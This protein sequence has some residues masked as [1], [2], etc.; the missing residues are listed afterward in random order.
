MHGL[1][2]A[3]LIVITLILAIGTLLCVGIL[4]AIAIGITKLNQKIEKITDMAEPVVNKASDTLDTVQRV[5][6]NVGEK[7]DVILTRGVELTDKVSGNVEKTATVVQQTV[8]TPL[9]KLS[10]VIAG[11]SKSLSVYAGNSRANGHNNSSDS[12]E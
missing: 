1:E 2:F 11:V 4:A 7:A 5:T 9:I 8:T 6:T 12:K 10:S 3:T